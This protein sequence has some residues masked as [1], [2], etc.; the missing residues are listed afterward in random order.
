VYVP[1]DLIPSVRQPAIASLVNPNTVQRAYEQLEREGLIAGRKGTGMVVV[2]NG[3]AVAQS[4]TVK[5]IKAAFAQGVALGREANLS[6]TEMDRIFRQVCSEAMTA[7][8]SR[9]EP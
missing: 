7:D 3:K 8:S 9:S 6:K 5:A 1:G 2:A 4:G